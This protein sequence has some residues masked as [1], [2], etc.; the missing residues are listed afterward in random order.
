[1]AVFLVIFSRVTFDAV[2]EIAGVV[3]M[4]GVAVVNLGVVIRFVISAVARRDIGVV[5]GIL[6]GN[7]AGVRVNGFVAFGF[8]VD[9][10]VVR[11]FFV[12]CFIVHWFFVDSLFVQGFCVQ[13]FIVPWFLA[14]GRRG[15]RLFM[16]GRGCRG[17]VRRTGGPDRRRLD[18][19][20]SGVLSVAGA[21]EPCPGPA[22]Q[23]GRP[24]CV[25]KACGGITSRPRSPGP[26]VGPGA[27]YGSA[28]GRRHRGLH[29]RSHQ[30]TGLTV[31][32]HFR[33]SALGRWV[34]TAGPA[35]C[36]PVGAGVDPRRRGSHLRS[37][38]L[39]HI[40][41]MLQNTCRPT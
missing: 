18:G 3:G 10:S 26:S 14:H 9:G 25:S 31:A 4:D 21:S 41:R 39:L 5:H 22:R 16:H 17:P 28:V 24:R 12:N 30:R 8:V 13:G 32:F 29:R 38:G 1:M 33:Q 35:V 2:G 15:G 6:T 34:S 40:N 23:T 27:L 37:P 19:I 11:G 20:T 7:T 36:H